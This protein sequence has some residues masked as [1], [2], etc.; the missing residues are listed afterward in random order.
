[1]G[2]KASDTVLKRHA[3]LWLTRVKILL[4]ARLNVGNPLLCLQHLPRLP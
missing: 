1:M 2:K 3:L 4:V